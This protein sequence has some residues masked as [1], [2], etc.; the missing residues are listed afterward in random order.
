TNA[1]TALY[2]S[3]MVS[4]TNLPPASSTYFAH[5]YVNSSTFHGRI[6]AQAG[7]LP[8][9]WR[10]GVAGSAG[11]VNKV[12]AVDLATNVDYQLVVGWDA[13]TSDAPPLSRER[14][15]SGLIR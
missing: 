8:N 15:L 14:R 11:T 4:C 9:T 10:L 6:F 13:T 3:F 2:A 7:A 5:F 1:Q 12:I